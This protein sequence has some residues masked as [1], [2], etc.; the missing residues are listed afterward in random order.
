[1]RPT[2]RNKVLFGRLFP[3]SSVAEEAG[4]GVTIPVRVRTACCAFSTSTVYRPPF[5]I[6]DIITTPSP[7]DETR[8]TLLVR[9]SPK[10]DNTFRVQ[11][12]TGEYIV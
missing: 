4:G 8:M 10:S 6:L 1:M 3:A 12:A 5:S 2:A 7:D 9:V 11:S